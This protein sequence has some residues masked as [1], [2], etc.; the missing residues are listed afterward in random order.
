MPCTLE[1]VTR[2]RRAA[3]LR[4]RPS[5]GI[6]LDPPARAVLRDF[7][8]CLVNTRPPPVCIG[9]VCGRARVE[10]CLVR[11]PPLPACRTVS[12][13]SEALGKGSKVAGRQIQAPEHAAD[14]SLFRL[15]PRDYVVACVARPI[16]PRNFSDF[17]A[18]FFCG[19]GNE[20]CALD[21]SNQ[22]RQT[23][24]MLPASG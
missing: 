9:R 8:I 13:W 4:R 16:S 1:F 23:P 17:G 6:F 18:P 24:G 14:N 3:V 7:A 19:Q 22:T 21:R 12:Y 11:N 5:V 20:S 2:Y 10:A 15:G